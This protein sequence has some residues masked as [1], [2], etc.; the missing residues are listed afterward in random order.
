MGKLGYRPNPSE[1]G[2]VTQVFYD[3]VTVYQGYANAL[4]LAYRKLPNG[5]WSG[6][7]E[8]ALVS[9]YEAYN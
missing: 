8:A 5:P 7:S 4:H 9:L 3:G 6:Q 1:V 2:T